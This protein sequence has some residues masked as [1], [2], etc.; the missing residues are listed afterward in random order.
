MSH[1]GSEIHCWWHARSKVE[2]PVATKRR[3][4]HFRLSG[5]L[6][7][8]DNSHYFGQGMRGFRCGDD[9]LRSGE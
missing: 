9:A 2:V 7:L 6:A 3:Q 8:V 1:V 4:Q 5:C